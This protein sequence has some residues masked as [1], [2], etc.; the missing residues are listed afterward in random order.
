MALSHPRVDIKSSSGQPY[1]GI[2]QSHYLISSG[3]IGSGIQHEGFPSSPR[4]SPASLVLV[5]AASPSVI[6][7]R[8][9]HYPALIAVSS[10]FD[11]LQYRHAETNPANCGSEFGLGLSGVDLNTFTV[12]QPGTGP[13]KISR[14]YHPD[15]RFILPVSRAACPSRLGIFLQ[16]RRARSDAPSDSTDLIRAFIVELEGARRGSSGPSSSMTSPMT[17]V[18]TQ[19]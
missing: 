19:A 17:R 9:S 13:K 8:L 4:L 11:A 14:D 2:L 15:V 6:I 1:A 16:E 5:Q 10:A 7:L 18:S 3:L 12:L